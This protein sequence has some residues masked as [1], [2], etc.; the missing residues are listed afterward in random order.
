[1]AAQMNLLLTTVADYNTRDKLM[2]AWQFG[3]KFWLAYGPLDKASSNFQG[4]EKLAMAVGSARAPWRILNE[5][6][7]ILK[8]KEL[9]GKLLQGD[10]SGSQKLDTLLN[11]AKAALMLVHW[12]T[13][14]LSFFQKT[15]LITKERSLG[16]TA[17]ELNKVGHGG[18]LSGRGLHAHH[19][20]SF[21]C[22]PPS[23]ISPCF[24]P[25]YPCRVSSFVGPDS[26]P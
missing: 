18:C 14:H 2:K 5:W 24:R 15:G 19:F 8:F 23:P 1:M 20:F 3:I 26:S 10:L 16:R 11:T 9:L 4:L 6:Q 13:G 21:S 17:A 12:T 7:E 25:T 22:M